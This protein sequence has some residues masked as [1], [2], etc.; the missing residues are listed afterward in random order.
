[1]QITAQLKIELSKIEQELK[2]KDVEIINLKE[3]VRELERKLKM[4]KQ[5]LDG[6]K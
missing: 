6:I 3:R 1:M 2:N 4:F 5:A